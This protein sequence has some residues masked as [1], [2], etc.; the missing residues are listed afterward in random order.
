MLYF[1]LCKQIIKC[2]LELGLIYYTQ[3]LHH[4]KFILQRPLRTQ[5]WQFAL[6]I[7]FYSIYSF[8]SNY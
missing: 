1:T 6:E 3:F 2:T 7:F 8:P 5:L 4:Q